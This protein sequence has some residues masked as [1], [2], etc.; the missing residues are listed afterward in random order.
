MGNTW[1]GVSDEKLVEFEKKLLTYSEIPLDEF[2]LS[3]V[4]ID[5]DGNFVRTIQVGDVCHLSFK[6][7]NRDLSKS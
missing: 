7:I 4:V 6:P 5:G 1:T 2:E 3:N